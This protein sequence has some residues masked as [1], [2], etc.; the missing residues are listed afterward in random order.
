M[1]ASAALIAFVGTTDLE[2]SDAFY[3]GVLGLEFVSGN[4]AANLYRAG[5]TQLRVTLVSE[6]AAPGYTVAGFVVDDLEAV[7]DDLVAKGVEF[8]RYPGFEQDERAIWTA[9]SGARFAWLN[10]P[11][12]NNLS[13]E[14]PAG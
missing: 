6:V 1:L 12:G 3:R 5:S 10:D 8:P 4:P 7:I 9:P 11:D 14:Q 13:I 2:R